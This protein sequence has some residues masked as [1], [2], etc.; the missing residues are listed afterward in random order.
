MRDFDF[1]NP[2]R[3]IFGRKSEE[4]VGEVLK[5]YGFKK[6][7]LICGQNS[8][9]KSGLF[10]LIVG[11]I[12]ESGLEYREFSGISPNPE[13]HFV[14]EGLA[15]AKE[16]NPDCLLAV[17]GGSVIDVAKSICANYYY[18][19]H[20]FDFNLKKAVPTKTLPL[21][22]V[23]TIA[24]A[25][26]ESS[27]SCVITD[28]VTKNKT[29]F[30]HP[31]NRPLFAI[32]DPELLFTL[33]KYQIAVGVADM[34]MHTM[35]RYFG[36]S[37]ENMICDEWALALLKHEVENA[38]IAYSNP[39]D[40]EAQAALMLDSSLSHDGL[41]SIGKIKSPFVVHALEHAISGYKPDVTH[42]AGIA[43]C[44]LGWAKY[45]YQK[46]TKKFA[47]LGRKLFNIEEQNDE[48]AAIIGI[49]SM[50]DFYISL[51]IPTTLKEVGINESDLPELVRLASCNGTRVIGLYPQ[52][53]NESDIAAVY[54]LCLNKEGSK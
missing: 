39:P 18:E 51:G 21:G 26:S 44:Y 54:A 12:Q 24:A 32:E 35:E 15:I 20:P 9:K 5:G 53:L 6:I 14:E 37:D 4:K 40:Y 13:L 52:P 47:A 30:N 28:P 1:I 49:T 23:L 34:M 27:D 31:L 22:V 43:I 16:Y 38:R 48:K 11:K 19:G 3:I 50:R 7:M 46:E 10:D 25:G 29:G 17:G 41:T 8:V 2:T 42:G 33:P 36:A 45:V